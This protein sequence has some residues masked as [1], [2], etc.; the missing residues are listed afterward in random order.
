MWWF[1]LPLYALVGIVLAG[2]IHHYT[3][4]EGYPFDFTDFLMITLLW[5]LYLFGNLK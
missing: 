1:V 5:P 3:R 2:C 4:S